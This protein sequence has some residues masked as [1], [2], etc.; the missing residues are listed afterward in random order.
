M[1]QI[2]SR[3]GLDNILHPEE[4]LIQ[5]YNKEKARGIFKAQVS[6]KIIQAE[7]K[8]QIIILNRVLLLFKENFTIQS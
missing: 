1:Q 6:S 8:T 5:V 3:V 4:P 7:R 2:F